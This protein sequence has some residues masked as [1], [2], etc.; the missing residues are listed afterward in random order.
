MLFETKRLFLR[1]FDKG[2]LLDLFEYASIEE[3]GL[4][5]GWIPHISR[6]DSELVL[7]MFIN[8]ENTFAIVYKGNNKVIG[9]ISLTRDYTRPSVNSKMMGYVL[10]KDYWGNGLMIEAVNRV[11]DYA[12][13]ELKLSLVSV[14][15]FD[16]NI[17]SK[18]VIE[19]AKFVYEGTFRNSF[20]M[21]NGEMKNRCFYS[22]TKEEYLKRLEN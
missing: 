15:H 16:D 4:N 12:F 8:D 10:S 18:R 9:S 22:M 17:Q 6:D 20:L 7:N 3:V 2:D 1:N 13:N 14:S 19:K 11:L 21:Y 5:A